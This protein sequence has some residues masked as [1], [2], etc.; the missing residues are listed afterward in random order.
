M[1]KMKYI[2]YE[3]A[4]CDSIVVFDSITNHSDMAEKI[5]LPVLGAGFITVVSNQYYPPEWK[6]YGE[7]TSLKIKSRPEDT[8]LANRM[9]P[10]ED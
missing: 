3:S 6:C 7:S 10:L 8:V 1:L 2:T 4:Y 5:G 9:L